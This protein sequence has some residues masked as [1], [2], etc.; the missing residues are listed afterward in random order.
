M[1]NPT[2]IAETLARLRVAFDD[3]RCADTTFIAQSRAVLP[4]AL[5]CVAALEHMACRCRK[6]FKEECPQ[7]SGVLYP[8]TNKGGVLNDEQFASVRAGD[9]Y[10]KSCK[11]AEAASGFKYWWERDLRDITEPCPRCAALAAFREAG[12]R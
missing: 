2:P 6:R 4:A 10:C 12:E 3:D 11:G 7:C 1:P 9:Y 5:D 8:V